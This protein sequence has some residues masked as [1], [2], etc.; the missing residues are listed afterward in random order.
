[1]GLE[2]CV[3]AGLTSIPIEGQNTSP[4][5]YMTAADENYFAFQIWIWIEC[6]RTFTVSTSRSQCPIH[7]MAS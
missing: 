6:Q 3:Q 5:P 1:M 2:D 4:V 7:C